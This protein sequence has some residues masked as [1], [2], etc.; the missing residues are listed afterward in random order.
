VG[1]L[2]RVFGLYGH[3]E[4]APHYQAVAGDDL[5]QVFGFGF[6]DGIACQG[7]LTQLMDVDQ[8]RIHVLQ[9]NVDDLQYLLIS[10]GDLIEGL[11]DLE[12]LGQAGGAGQVD[13]DQRRLCFILRAQLHP[14]H[15]LH[16]LF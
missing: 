6:R 11:L 5:H 16:E 10:G 1:Q 13:L 9:A 2:A 12:Q 15:P 7:I 8:G 14:H 3:H 4:Q